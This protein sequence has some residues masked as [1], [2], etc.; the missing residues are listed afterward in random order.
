M[1]VR[2]VRFRAKNEEASVDIEVSEASAVFL[3]LLTRYLILNMNRSSG[4][5]GSKQRPLRRK[6]A[7]WYVEI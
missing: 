3:L 6:S 5:R 1:V 7:G 2:L 4:M